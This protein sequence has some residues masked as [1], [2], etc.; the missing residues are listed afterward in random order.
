MCFQENKF[1][2]FQV[3]ARGETHSNTSFQD[4]LL[5]YTWVKGKQTSTQLNWTENI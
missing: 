2:C 1:G 3:S 4:T 5:F